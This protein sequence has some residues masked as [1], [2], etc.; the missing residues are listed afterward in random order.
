MDDAYLAVLE[1]PLGET[2]EVEL[3]Y[4]ASLHSP[5]LQ[6]VT[7]G[8]QGPPGL[9][10]IPGPAGGTALQRT[11]GQALSALRA[12]YELDGQVLYLDYRDAA[13][14]DLLLGIT[15]TAAQLGEPINVQRSGPLED[16][17]WS[18]TPGPVWLGVDGALS[19]TPPSDGYDVL[20]GAAVSTTRITLNLN[21][22]I[23]LE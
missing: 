22:P 16:A 18:W 15:L 17:G 1:V 3:E 4:L 23:E 2:G 20:L 21:D 9:Q 8:E 19:Q 6:T 10:G 12:V 14:I 13:H 11:A 7:L 5:E